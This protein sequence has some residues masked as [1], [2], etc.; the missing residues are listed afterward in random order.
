MTELMINYYYDQWLPCRLR[1]C[2]PHSCSCVVWMTIIKVVGFY[3]QESSWCCSF[4]L[5]NSVSLRSV[6]CWPN[7]CTW[8]N[9]W[10]PDY[11]CS[12]PH[13]DH[14]SLRLAFRWHKHW[15]N[16][17]TVCGEVYHLQRE[18]F[19]FADN[20]VEILNEHLSLLVELFTPTKV[21]REC[22]K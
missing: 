16:C 15:V 18:D 10:P 19:W 20:P 9:S 3:D 2:L 12:W 17:N 7:P 6:G 11:W 22:N 5:H 13:S 8:W 1:M 14:S 21:V 4:W